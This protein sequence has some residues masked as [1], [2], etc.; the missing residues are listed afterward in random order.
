ML[1]VDPDG[2]V[3]AANA[4]HLAPYLN[5]SEIAIETGLPLGLDARAT[6]T[7]SHF[8]LKPREQLTL[9]TDGVPE[10]RNAQGELFG[11]EQ[12]AAIAARSAEEIASTAQRFGQNDDVT[13]V[14]L[15]WEP[16]L[17]SPSA[18]LVFSE[19]PIVP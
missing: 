7:A 2:D 5:G 11:F 4:V 19:A 12:T 18:S 9:M 13:V 3:T 8:R 15:T 10:A 17:L 6:Y 1:R 14:K 16:A